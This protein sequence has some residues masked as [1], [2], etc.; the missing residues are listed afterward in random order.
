MTPRTVDFRYKII[1][2]GA[3]FGDLYPAEGQAPRINMN[4]ADTVKTCLSGTFLK[5]PDSFDRLTDAI[6]P[7]LIRKLRDGAR[8]ILAGK[9]HGVPMEM[10]G[11]PIV[12]YDLGF[13]TFLCDK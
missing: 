13:T 4:D 10:H 2:N 6:R 3:D 1:R 5:P 12:R 9:I 11:H 7:E 8:E